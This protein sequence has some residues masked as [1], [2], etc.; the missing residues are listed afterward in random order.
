MDAAT[1]ARQCCIV[2][3]LWAFI[4][5][6]AAIEASFLSSREPRS[7][8]TLAIVLWIESRCFWMLT[9]RVPTLASRVDSRLSL[10]EPTLV[11]ICV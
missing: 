7:L 3:A 4:S 1:L 11:S 5:W 6:K 10:R 8:L 9:W 2:C